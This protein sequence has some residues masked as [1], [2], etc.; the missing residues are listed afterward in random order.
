MALGVAGGLIAL[1]I[2]SLADFNLY[3][4]AN[5]MVFCSLVGVGLGILRGEERAG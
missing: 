3:I 4:P 2:H 5:L 1:L